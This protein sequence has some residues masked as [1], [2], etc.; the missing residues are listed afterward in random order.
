MR[1]FSERD[2][3]Y[4]PAR[5]PA[6]RGRSPGACGP[7]VRLELDKSS[8]RSSIGLFARVPLCSYQVQRQRWI[9]AYL[10]LRKALI[11]PRYRAMT[12]ASGALSGSAVSMFWAASYRSS[13]ASICRATVVMWP[14]DIIERWSPAIGMTSRPAWGI[15]HAIHWWHRSPAEA[16]SPG[17]ASCETARPMR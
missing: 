11:S 8:A 17:Y 5:G 6:R 10:G 1:N 16:S 3:R 7:Y 14:P 12:R 9:I 13:T 4:P 15:D 2:H